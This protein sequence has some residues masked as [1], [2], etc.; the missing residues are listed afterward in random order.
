MTEG[1][2]VTL[3]DQYL[4][5]VNWLYSA[6]LGGVKLEVDAAHAEEAVRI[7]GRSDYSDLLDEDGDGEPISC[8]N[9]GANEVVSYDP[10]RKLA[11]LTLFP[12]WPL[13]LLIGIPF[14][15]WRARAIC[16]SCKYKS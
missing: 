8:T 5:G 3:Q 7:L 4:V 12:M 9:C 1:I 14:I 10:L 6:A 13:T 11:A 2:E 15:K 16:L